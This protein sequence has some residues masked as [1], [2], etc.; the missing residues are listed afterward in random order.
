MRMFRKTVVASILILISA[1]GLTGCGKKSALAPPAD[2]E[3]P[4][5]YPR[6]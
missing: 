4:K 3:Y 2:A 1:L 6:Q 5:Q